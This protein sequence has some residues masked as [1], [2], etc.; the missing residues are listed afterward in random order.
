M[1]VLGGPGQADATIEFSI[2]NGRIA[3][4]DSTG[5]I[6]AKTL[7]STKVTAKAIGTD[8]ITGQK[9]VFSSDVVNVH[10]VKLFGVKIKAP[11]MKMRVDTEMPIAWVGLDQVNQNAFSYGSALPNLQVDWKL[12]NHE[13]A[14]L[15]SPLWPNGITAN[16]NNNGAMRLIAKKPGRTIIKLNAKI[17]APIEL[18]GQAQLDKDMEF[19]DEIEVIIFEDINGKSPFIG[20]NSL[21]MT[22]MSEHQLSIKGKLNL[23]QENVSTQTSKSFQT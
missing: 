18:I 16:S 15:E 2:G 9:I 3:N 5:L 17:T 14:A 6:D 20:R 19:S 22:P 7:G 1:Q 4:L 12:T 11:I 8:K 13:V 10:V 23:N 21:L